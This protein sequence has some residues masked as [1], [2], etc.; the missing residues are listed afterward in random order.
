M[1]N[2]YNITHKIIYICNYNYYI[3]YNQVEICGCENGGNC[4]T[5]GTTPSSNPR[6]L[7]CICSQGIV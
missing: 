3:N 1:Y 4:T 7:N 2:V 6:I 5:E